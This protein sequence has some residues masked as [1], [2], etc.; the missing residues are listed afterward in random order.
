MNRVIDALNAE[1]RQGEIERRK[2]RTYSNDRQK[3]LHTK[4]VHEKGLYVRRIIFQINE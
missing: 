2:A 4:Y 1:A 3:M